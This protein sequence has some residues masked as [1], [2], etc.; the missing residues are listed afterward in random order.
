MASSENSKDVEQLY[1]EFCTI[2]KKADRSAI[3]PS[4]EKFLKTLKTFKNLVEGHKTL[5][6]AIGKL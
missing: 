2:L 1:K 4:K 6:T 5:L 3:I